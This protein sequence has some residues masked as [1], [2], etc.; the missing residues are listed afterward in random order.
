MEHKRNCA[1]HA[2]NRPAGQAL[3]PPPSKDLSLLLRLTRLLHG[4]HYLYCSQLAI[5][6][7]L[8]QLLGLPLEVCSLLLLL[9]LLIRR[10]RPHLVRLLLCGWRPVR[11]AAA[12]HAA[13]CWTPP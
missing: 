6:S 1:P 10:R 12:G 9:L 13:S 5:M 8:R 7:Q 11:V 4:R 3:P 2:A